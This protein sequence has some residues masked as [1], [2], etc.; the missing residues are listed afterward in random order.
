[1]MRLLANRFIQ[2]VL[3]LLL[4][5]GMVE[6]R[7]LNPPALEHLRQI[8]FDYYNRLLPRPPG[9]D[10]VIVDIDEESIRAMGQWPW[11]RT[12]VA[13]LAARIK[14]L[15]AKSVAFDMVFSEPDRTSPARMAEQF[16]QAADILKT[17]PDNDTAFARALK[18]MGNAV[19]GF[20][21]A[22]QATGAR[23]L[24]KAQFMNAGAAPD[25]LRFVDSTP[26]YTVTLPEITEAAAGNGSFGV[27]PEGDGVI[28]KVPLLIGLRGPEGRAR[29]MYPALAL[30]ALRVAEGKSVYKVMSF[31]ERGA[32]GYGI[33]SVALGAR[34]IPTDGKGNIW[35]YYAGHR[36]G[37]YV[38]AVK[39][40]RGEAKPEDFR[41]KIALVG[42]S[43][44]GLLDLRSSPLDKVL[45]GVEIHAE[46]I[47]QVL[48][49]QFLRRPEALDGAELVV[50]AGVSL[51]IILL[52]PFTG[53]G[54]LAFLA[55]AVIAG[56][57]AV[58][59]WAYQAQG[60]LIAPVY[61][62]LT[63]IAIFIASSILTNLRTEMEK[64]QVRTAFA[65]YISPDVMKELAGDPSKLKLGGEVRDLSVMFTDI[66]NF[67]TISEQ[68]DPAEL[69][70]MMNDFLTP[71]T[72]CVLES[73]GTVDKYMGDAMMAFWNA[74]LEDK[75]HARHACQAALGMIA[76][77]G[78]V[79]AALH[80]KLG[81]RYRELKAGIGIHTGRCSVGNMGS[82]Q[83]FAYSALG[84]TV[85]LASR[86]ESQ[87]KGYGVATLISEAVRSQAPEFASVEVD[88]LTVKGRTEP[89]R[90]H[91]LLGGPEM[92]AQADF[93][94][95]AALHA[96]MLAAYRA[97]AWDKALSLAQACRA[98]RADLA[99][100]YALYA[101]RISSYKANPPAPEWTGVWVAKDK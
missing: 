5:A 64:R 30:E 12:R 33:T 48:H 27:S 93:K 98:H 17:L 8:T 47:E 38:P 44:I 18:D 22:N 70:K 11:P 99:G 75:D 10:V 1:M 6:L 88:L 29:E 95:F 57:G 32:Q 16:P 77:L 49:G 63:I 28:R 79:N 68:M 101:E 2:I 31:G 91:T 83:R 89:E 7:L 37:I 52:A 100:L 81:P 36:Q 15:G 59:L 56:G 3:L 50:M 90:V 65:H 69:I 55:F 97:R 82:K 43:A 67:T 25:P 58:S 86:L 4:L 87:T 51:L 54:T 96:E 66:R 46:I 9:N 45:P 61:P 39:V 34:E 20:V 84:D 73:R 13:E 62:V 78:P 71:M 40:L 24:L 26:N 85:N 72:S 35:V 14:A 41:D 42:T 92:A 21:D 80:E 23:P 76:A 74:P 94:A 60:L 19:T 53:A